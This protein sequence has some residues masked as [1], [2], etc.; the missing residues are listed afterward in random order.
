MSDNLSQIIETNSKFIDT[1]KKMIQSC[2]SKKHKVYSYSRFIVSFFIRRA[3]EMFDSFLILIKENRIIDSTVLLRSLMDMG[4]SLGYIF[5]KDIDET[6]NEVRALKYMLEGNR[7]QL[8]MINSNLEGFKEYDGN[9]ET[10]RDEIKEEIKKIEGLLKDK[11]G[12]EDWCLPKSTEERAKLS[13]FDV[14][15]RA[16]NQ[17]YRD[18]STIEHHNVLFGQHYVDNEE[19]EPK[20][21]INHLEHFPQFEP[22]VSLILFRLFFLRIMS[23]FNYAF[24]LKWESKLS[25][26]NEIHEKEYEILK[27]DQ[28]NSK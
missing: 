26:L 2:H 23:E 1:A 16:Y 14:L 18:L 10:R 6:E 24:Q 8:K 5:A 19:C 7:H 15:K 3:W 28:N 12:I 4:I 25:E 21:Q 17:S 9:I 22:S 20:V 11:Y 27:K 13:N